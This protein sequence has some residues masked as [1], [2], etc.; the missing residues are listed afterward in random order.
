[1]KKTWI[2]TL[3]ILFV[4]VLN[5]ET[6]GEYGFQL[7]KIS[8]SADAAA[9]AGTGAFYSNSSSRFIN[10]PAAA[11]IDKINAISFNQNYWIFGTSI[12][13]LS[14]L[15]SSRKLSFG[16]GYRY[17]DY[18]T[19]DGATDDG[20][21]T[22]EFNPMD[23][24]FTTGIGYRITPSHFV[25]INLSVLYEKI[26]IE[27]ALGGSADLGYHYLTPVKNF[28]L[29]AVLKNLGKTNDLG[30]EDIDLPITGE[31][32][33]IGKEL[34]HYLGIKK[35]KLDSE[36]KLLKY[37]DDDEIKADLGI[38]A[39]VRKRLTLKAGYKFNHD[40]QSFS[41]GF[42]VTLRRIAIDYAY[43]PF[44]DDIDDVHMIQVG[45]KF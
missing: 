11:N 9:M 42:G 45:F 1:M 38:K 40:T 17:L 18:G 13:S 6:S 12:N 7:L 37:V 31:L 28:E 30:T 33:F 16:I 10:N 4:A 44:S 43:V 22:G 39:V 3:L 25:G 14:Y 20:Q 27:S 5:A 21:P 24:I 36:L 34:N 15:R 41:A 2:I 35:V 32:S 23:L 26:D 8:A 19:L 29:A